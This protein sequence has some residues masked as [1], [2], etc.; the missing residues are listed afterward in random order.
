MDTQEVQSW[1]YTRLQEHQGCQEVTE[2]AREGT[3]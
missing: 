2:T 3:A 1:A